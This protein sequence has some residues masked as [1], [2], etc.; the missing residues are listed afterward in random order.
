[1]V[2]WGGGVQL[3][4]RACDTSFRLR[5]SN[6]WNDGCEQDAAALLFLSQIPAARLKRGAEGEVERVLNELLRDNPGIAEAL[7]EYQWST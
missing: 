6:G 7:M 5:A 3:A 1:M 2:L 4:P